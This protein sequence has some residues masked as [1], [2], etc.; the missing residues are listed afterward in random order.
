LAPAELF[1]APS[2]AREAKSRDGLDPQRRGILLHRL[3]QE[4]PKFPAALRNGE[5]MRILARTAGDFADEARAKLAAEALAVLDHPEFAILFGPQSRGEVELLGRLAGSGG[6]DERV[7]RIDRLVVMPDSILIADYKTDARQPT[8]PEDAP[9]AYLVQLARYRA[10]LGQSFP[11]RAMRV[12]LVWTAG[13]AIQEV[14]ANLL[15]DI[16]RR[17]TSL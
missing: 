14:P 9:E 3:L 11:G 15:D 16:W 6:E 13:P 12:F 17:V 2:K 7:R 8:R 10:L 5:A 4:L 1:R